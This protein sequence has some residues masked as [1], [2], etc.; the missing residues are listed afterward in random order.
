MLRDALLENLHRAELN[1][2]EEASAYQQLLADFGITQEQLATASAG[3]ARRSRTRCACSSCRSRAAAS[4]GRRAHRRSRPGD[5]VGRR[6][7]RRWSGSP[8]RS[9]TRIS[10]CVLRRRPPAAPDAASAASRGRRQA[11]GT[12]TRSPSASVTPR[13]PREG[14]PRGE[15][16]HDRHRLRHG[17]RPQSHPGCSSWA[18]PAS[19]ASARRGRLTPPARSRPSGCRGQRPRVEGKDR[20]LGEAGHRVGLEEPRGTRSVDDEVDPEM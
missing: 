7:P 16:G 13:H 8:T 17:R 18:S 4:R 19:R 3:P 15:Q 12:S 2:L 10:R 6:R 1:P 5:P 9:S 11:R 14:R 20:G